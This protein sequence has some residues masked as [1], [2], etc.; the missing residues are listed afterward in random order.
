MAKEVEGLQNIA[1]QLGGGAV[2]FIA[3]RDKGFADRTDEDIYEVLC[4]YKD[5]MDEE[6][7]D[8]I[9]LQDAYKKKRY[10]KVMKEISAMYC[11]PR[12]KQK[13]RR[14]GKYGPIDVLDHRVNRLGQDV[15]VVYEF[16]KQRF[17]VE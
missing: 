15:E 10:N 3:T 4:W 12:A 5:G 1:R 7:N 8:I 16:I 11:V 17:M 9:P 2:A 14:K 13:M 6:G